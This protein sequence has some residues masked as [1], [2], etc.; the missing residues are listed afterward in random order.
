MFTPK[1]QWPG[2]SATPKS[3]ASRGKDKMV[4]FIDAPPP[5]PT[6]L[7]SDNGSRG[8]VENMEDW[9]RF[10]EVGLLDE[11]A[12]ERRDREAIL[13]R[14]RKLEKE[15]F[16][17]QYNM[18]LLLMEKKEWTSK[19]EEFQESLLAAQEVL[20]REKTG[21]LIAVAQVEEREANLRKALDVE[22]QCVTELER[23]LREIRGEHEKIKMTSETKL[24]S[25]NALASGIE[26]RSLEV[27]QKLLAADAKLAEASRKSLELERKLQEVETRE[28][29]LKRERTSFTS[30]RDA[31]EATF[32][33]LKEDMREWER[34]LQEGEERL[35][36]NRRHI[37]EKEE[38]TNELNRTFKERER[39]LEEE[40]KKVELANLSLK[41]K[42]EEVNKKLADLV[43]KEE[44]AESLRTNLLTKEKELN[45]LT[46]MLSS[47]ERV[48]I[49]NILDAH[50]S[51]LEIKKHEFEWE[52]EEKRKLLEEEMK[53]KLENLDKKESEVNHMEEKLKK[54]EQA[55]E[56]KSERVKEKEKENDLKLKGVKEKEKALKLES[57]NLD[58]LRKEVDSD[59]ESLKSLRDEIEKTKAEISHKEM[60]IKD[61][62]EKLSITDAERK[63][64]NHLKSELKQEIERYKHQQ[65][66]LCKETDDLK[67]DRRKFEEEWEALDEKRIELSRELEKVEHEKKLTEK[68][69]NSGEKQLKEDKIANENYIKNEM[70]ALRVAKESFA[71]TMKHEQ[72]A[73]SEKARNEHNQLLHDFETRRRDLEADML[74]KQEEM[75][76]DLQERERA[77]HENVEKENSNI[78]HLKEVVQ[79]EIEDIKSQMNRLDKDK[80]N[81][82][83][84]KRQLEEQQLEMQKDI[85][86]LGVL[87]KKLKLQR[88]QFIEER[89]RF[90]AFVERLKT[91]QNC[92]NTTNDYILSDLQIKEL[93]EK[94]ASPLQ[95]MGE[96][97]FEKVANYGS[98]VKQ[99]PI[100]D[101]PKSSSGGRISWLLKKCTPKIFNLSPNKKAQNVPSQNLDQALSDTV[102]E[103]DEGP[104]IPAGTATRVE[105]F[106]KGDLGVEEVPE[107]AEQSELTKHRPKSNRQ[108]RGG[109]PRTRSVKAVVEDAE[110]FLR[111]K[112]GDL[113]PNE[114]QN[115]EEGKGDSSLAGKTASGVPRKRT[116]AQSSRMTGSEDGDDSE[117][118]S[119]SVTAGGRRKRRQTGAPAV[120]NTV[121]PRYNLRRHKITDEGVTASMD[122]ERK[123]DKEVVDATLSRD[124]EI[125][126]AP[127][128]ESASQN[129]NPV[130]SSHKN[131]QTQMFSVTRIVRFQTSSGANVDENADLKSAENVGLSEEVSG[132]PEYNDDEHESTLVDIEEEE[133]DDD[134]EDENPGEASVTKK[135]WTFFTS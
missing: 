89:S 10:R 29:V 49:Q 132:T 133:D 131:V 123:T 37:Y 127:P 60:L 19:H 61:E 122:S 76:R 110:A 43:A 121:K 117:G 12:L 106:L 69:K 68:L 45:A 42:E 38:K 114:E 84:N 50:R 79:K 87:S 108:P 83:L 119:G 74:K 94:E 109:V 72:L 57:K 96:E 81:I 55:L 105:D 64:H 18:G 103:N 134:D 107:E 63:E 22:R 48:E 14:V 5:P 32:L 98:N 4:G 1:R 35:C 90:I 112:S 97:L 78:S 71:E 21:H 100:E 24:A 99:T 124:N 34:K 40:Q 28:S 62:T 77:I 47:R 56:K 82:A 70:E 129:H 86:E 7:L 126:S 95:A 59:K 93:D 130:D 128:D 101:D 20:K 2:P 53:V 36:Q 15:L 51:A 41:K 115:K 104:S 27:Q 44:K 58:L 65:D 8:D 118:N 135:L 91:C 66:M 16:D 52:M 102:A 92:G 25:A 75:E 39:G 125:T 88:E 111:R 17:Y 54:Q 85:D 67:Q 120:Q 9:R 33:K 23:S 26:D 46:E 11:A 3:A 113:K 80:T 30:E 6:G 116:R 31:H 73:L 13:E